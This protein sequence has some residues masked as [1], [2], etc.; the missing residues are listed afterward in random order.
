MQLTMK[1]LSAIKKKLPGNFTSIFSL[2]FIIVA[3]IFFCV[4]CNRGDKQKP[5]P[6]EIK[7]E[8][9]MSAIIESSPKKTNIP[10]S[11]LKKD[12]VNSIDGAELVLIPGG[13]FSMGATDTDK[14]ADEDEKPNRKV[15]VKSF[16]IYKF[17]VTNRQ[18]ADFIGK[19]GHKPEGEW[20][21]LH[22]KFTDDHPVVEVSWEDAVAY[23]KWAGGRLPAEAEWEKAARG[24]DG[25]IYPWGNRWDPDKCNMKL[26]KTKRTNVAR[27]EEHDD[28]WYGTLPVGSFKTGVS[29]Y[30]VFDMAGN[31]E[32]WCSDYFQ[33]DYY[34]DSPSRNPRGP[35]DGEARVLRGGGFF[36][37]KEDVRCTSRED[38]DPAKWCNLYGFRVV[39]D[40]IGE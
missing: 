37:K 34:K 15:D 9:T 1:S 7:P 20:K 10:D 5:T 31:V 36:A 2:F 27:I 16:Y 22:N 40:E 25:R 33:E 17:E 35:R 32:E 8:A 24:T 19:T 11:T 4:G 21:L 3:M 23:C 14:E 26:M 18:Y 28:I 13:E 38:D 30:G 39:I 29:P 12:L 6:N